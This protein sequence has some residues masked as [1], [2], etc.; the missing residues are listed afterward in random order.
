LKVGDRVRFYSRAKIADEEDIIRALLAE[1][2]GTIFR[3]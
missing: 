3:H 1:M 2:E